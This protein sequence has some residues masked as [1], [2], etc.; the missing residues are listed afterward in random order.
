MDAYTLHVRSINTKIL[1]YVVKATTAYREV[2]KDQKK[3]SSES[4]MSILGC[5]YENTSIFV[6]FERFYFVAYVTL[7][8]RIILRLIS[9]CSN[10]EFLNLYFIESH[11]NKRHEVILT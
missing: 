5:Y 10:I 8:W 9:C 2:H 3:V 6:R 11:L 7:E 4:V 1:S